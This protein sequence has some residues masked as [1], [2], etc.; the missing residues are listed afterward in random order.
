MDKLTVHRIK[1]LKN[2][3]QDAVEAAVNTTAR[4]HRAIAQKPYT[5]L[6][7]IAPIAEAAS[8]LEQAQESLTSGFYHGIIAVTRINSAIAEQLI[9]DLERQGD[10]Q[11]EQPKSG[12][13]RG[14]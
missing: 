2:F 11:A 13:R 9:D 1:G 14:R 8:A 4:T 12:G 10:E 6:K 5:S 3:I 7:E